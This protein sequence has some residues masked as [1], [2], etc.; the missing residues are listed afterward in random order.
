[1]G[2]SQSIR[3]TGQSVYMFNQYLESGNYMFL[4]NAPF[5]T[6]MIV[7][8]LNPVPGL[9]FLDQDP[10]PN[11]FNATLVIPQTGQYG[12]KII[13]DRNMI[14]GTLDVNIIKQTQ[15]GNGNNSNNN[16]SN[17]DDSVKIWNRQDV[18]DFIS[19]YLSK[20]KL[21]KWGYPDTPGIIQHTPKGYYG[22]YDNTYHW[23]YTASAKL[24]DA[25]RQRFPGYF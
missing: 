1:M 20:N 12:F 19:A 14:Q 15:G 18:Q 11:V 9:R 13:L 2:N 7:T 22:N 23:V 4:V 10:T 8:P 6:Q 5:N 3:M 17:T 16:N 25:V 24:R 21:N